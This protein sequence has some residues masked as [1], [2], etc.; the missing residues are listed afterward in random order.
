[1]IKDLTIEQRTDIKSI[2]PDEAL[3]IL[4]KHQIY[5]VNSEFLT[6]IFTSD[7]DW[8][9]LDYIENPYYG[10]KR[11]A[12]ADK[13]YC[14]CGRELKYQFIIE[15]VHTGDIKR[16]GINHFE[17]HTGVP[18]EVAHNIRLGMQR[19]NRW[20][21]D[22]LMNYPN[23]DEDEAQLL[24]I[25]FFKADYRKNT[26]YFTKKENEIINDFIS[27]GLPLPAN[28]ITKIQSSVKQIKYVKKLFLLEQL[29]VASLCIRKSFSS[30]T[31]GDAL[32]SDELQDLLIQSESTLLEVYPIEEA[33]DIIFKDINKK[34]YLKIK[35][36]DNRYYKVF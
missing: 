16:L 5:R 35:H 10:T 25:E 1:M 36:I 20:L 2:I 4:H 13:L 26:L 7:S 33:L 6:N 30:L 27:V 17:Q 14:E 24:A 29:P 31:N 28:L 9:F 23:Y 15:S 8:K 34:M 11:C 19:I 12:E 3:D 18:P 32:T 21:D 22:I